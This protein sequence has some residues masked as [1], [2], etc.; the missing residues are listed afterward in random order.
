MD[1]VLHVISMTLI[2]AVSVVAVCAWMIS[3]TDLVRRDD[4]TAGERIGWGVAFLAFAPVAGIVYLR[5]GPG[6]D[7]LSQWRTRH[8]A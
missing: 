8:T 4:I 5:C 2:A 6:E 3:V 7:C 1:Q